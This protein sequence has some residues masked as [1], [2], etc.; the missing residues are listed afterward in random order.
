M[1]IMGFMLEQGWGL[2]PEQGLSPLTPLTLTTDSISH[3][4][5]KSINMAG[6]R[7]CARMQNLCL[8]VR[9]CFNSFFFITYET[10][11]SGR[12]SMEAS[13]S[14]QPKSQLA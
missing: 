10:D 8:R 7:M 1:N 13:F 2:K 12:K 14:D 11:D 9:C 4:I 5:V 3:F 6:I